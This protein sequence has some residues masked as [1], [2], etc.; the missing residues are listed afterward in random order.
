M[1][2]I[3]LL[4]IKYVLVSENLYRWSLKLQDASTF[5]YLLSFVKLFKVVFKIEE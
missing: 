5:Q 3:K 1:K 4:K 2:L